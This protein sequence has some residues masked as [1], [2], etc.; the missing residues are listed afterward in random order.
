MFM[1]IQT[2][3]KLS[4]AMPKASTGADL[5]RSDSLPPGM[6][7]TFRNLL[8]CPLWQQY[9][10]KAA[11]YKKRVPSEPLRIMREGRLSQV[12][13]LMS[14]M[15]RRMVFSWNSILSVSLNWMSALARL[16]SWWLAL[17]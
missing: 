17:K 10:V 6:K 2:N 9:N 14:W 4:L 16:C 1:Q 3:I 5:A 8:D 15:M 13:H 7:A 12:G 11:H